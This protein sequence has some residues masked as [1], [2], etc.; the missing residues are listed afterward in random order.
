MVYSQGLKKKTRSFSCEAEVCEDLT[1][2]RRMKNTGQTYLAVCI[3]SYLVDIP[4]GL[5]MLCGVNV[6]GNWVSD[7]VY[8]E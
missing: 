7:T 8:L 2:G 4:H 3:I 1:L 5:N 6:S